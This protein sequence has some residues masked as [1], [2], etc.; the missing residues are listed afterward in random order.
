MKFNGVSKIFY[1]LSSFEG[2]EHYE[3]R[4]VQYQQVRVRYCFHE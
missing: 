4:R 2:V 1:Y 3:F